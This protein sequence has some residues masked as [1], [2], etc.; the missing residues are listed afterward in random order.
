MEYQPIG[1]IGCSLV[2]FYTIFRF[3]KKVSILISLFSGFTGSI[4]L[5]FYSFINKIWPT[6]ITNFVLLLSILFSFFKTYNLRIAVRN[7]STKIV[8]VEKNSK[9][10]CYNKSETLDT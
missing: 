9:N 6:F 7:S 4:L 10:S 5:M 1:F 8:D 2:C 3:S